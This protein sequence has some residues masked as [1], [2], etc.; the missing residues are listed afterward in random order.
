MIGDF[1]KTIIDEIIERMNEYI[2]MKGKAYKDYNLAI[3]KWL[4]EETSKNPKW[5]NELKA[6]QEVADNKVY[7]PKRSAKEVKD[8]LDKL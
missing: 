8:I 2:G 3:R 5:L 7:E 1:D 4:R 6:E